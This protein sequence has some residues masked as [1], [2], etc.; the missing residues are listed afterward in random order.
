MSK[1][2][3]FDLA[4]VTIFRELA[5]SFPV[6]PHIKESVITSNPSSDKLNNI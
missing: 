2:I 4:V 3:K 6:N 1:I 5:V